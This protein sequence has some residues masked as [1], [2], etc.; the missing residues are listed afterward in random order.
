MSQIKEQNKTP[1]KELNKMETRN[2]PDVKFKILVRG[3]VY[4]LGENFNKETGNIKIKI[5]NIKKNQS[6]IKD[7]LNKMKN[8]FKVINWSRSS[9]GSNQQLGK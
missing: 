1:G 4:E 7:T 5:E 9:R 6:E 8:T 3:R 2:L